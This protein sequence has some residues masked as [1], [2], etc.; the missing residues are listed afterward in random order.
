LASAPH[1]LRIGNLARMG[2]AGCLGSAAS[3]G[4]ADT[5]GAD[6]SP[7]AP[8]WPVRC[9]TGLFQRPCFAVAAN[10]VDDWPLAGEGPAAR[11]ERHAVWVFGLPRRRICGRLLA[12]GWG[13][14]RSMRCAALL[15]EECAAIWPVFVAG[16]RAVSGRRVYG[17]T[18]KLMESHHGAHNWFREE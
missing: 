2:R 14:P 4:M 17:D 9:G 1:G 18:P 8:L 11:A 13:R 5:I 12:I 7:G 3:L 16:S 6:G 10:R 15:G